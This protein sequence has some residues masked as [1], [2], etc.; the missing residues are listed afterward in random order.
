MFFV[1]VIVFSFTACNNTYVPKPEGYFQIPLPEKEYQVFDQSGYPYSFEYPVYAKVVK[2]SS[3]FGEKTENPWWINIDFPQFNGRIYI[4]YKDIGTNDFKKLLND[5]FNLTNKHSVKATSIDD[6]T[7][8]TPNGVHG[9]YFKVGGNVAT[10][11]Q[12][13]LTDSTKHFLRGALY[14]D[15]TPNQDSLKPV[16][17]FL[18]E[19]MKHFINTFRWKK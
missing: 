2:D 8:S 11:N 15:A 6:S 5:A 1:L 7:M 4:S 14:F 13:F 16:N 12:F 19:D 10:S 17:A 18:A 3:F 9:V